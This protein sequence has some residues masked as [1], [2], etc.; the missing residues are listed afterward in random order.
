M[1]GIEF[2]TRIAESANT[3]KRTVY[4]VLSEAGRE[5]ASLL[6]RGD[7]LTLLGLGTFYSVDKPRFNWNHPDIKL[8]GIIVPSYRVPQ[9]IPGEAF[10]ETVKGDSYER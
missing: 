4:T 9:F 8:D 3:D 7:S 6:A 5:L 1:T 2:V 10:K